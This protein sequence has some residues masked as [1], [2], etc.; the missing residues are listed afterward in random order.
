MRYPQ[1]FVS[2]NQSWSPVYVAAG[3]NGDGDKL[4]AVEVTLLRGLRLTLQ[5]RGGRDFARQRNEFTNLVTGAAIRGELAILRQRVGGNENRNG[6]VDRDSGA[7]RAQ[8]RVML[9]MVGWFPRRRPA[10]SAGTLLVRTGRDA[11]LV[12]VDAAGERIWRLNADHIRRW[13]AEHR[14]RLQRWSE[15]HKLEERPRASFQS[16]REAAVLLFRRRIE[17][18]QKEA[19]AQLAGF[20][21]RRQTATVLFDD[22]DRDF[23]EQFDWSGFRQ[24]LETK[25][26][27][28]GVDFE[29]TT[30][31]SVFPDLA[32]PGHEVEFAEE[33]Q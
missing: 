29:W 26:D 11:F 30:G 15:D 9:K 22:S 21:R 4:P 28:F 24:R 2:P 19:A 33:E 13:T 3:K 10:P 31:P 25:L 1:P 23:F 16:R 20:A 12:A 6:T 8:F 7:Q 32:R 18:F 14:R 5:L 17:S 27:E